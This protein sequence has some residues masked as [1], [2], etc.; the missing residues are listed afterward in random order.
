MIPS[1]INL[2]YLKDK[3]SVCVFFCGIGG[4]SMLSLAV[5]TKLNGYSVMGSDTSPTEETVSVCRQHRIPLFFSHDGDN[6]DGCNFFVYTAA[7]ASDNPELLRAKQENNIR[8]FTRSEYLGMITDSIPLSIGISGTHGKS[9]VTHLTSAVFTACGCDPIMLAGAGCTNNGEENSL[10][11]GALRIGNESTVIYEACE[12]SRS[13][14]DTHPS[15]AVILNVEREHTDIYPTLEIARNAFFEFAYRSHICVITRDCPTC[16]EI[17]K[18]LLDKGKR[19][20]TFSI[21]DKSADVFAH[22]LKNEH[23]R[24]AF[25]VAIGHTGELINNIKLNVPG[26][27]NVKNAL[28]SIAVAVACEK[29]SKNGIK[30]AL[31]GFRGI[32]RR[33]EYIGSINGADVYDD[34]AHHP[35]EIKAILTAAKALGYDRIV[36]AFQPH[37]Y[38]R[39]YEFFDDFV[40][41]LSLCDEVIVSDIF[42]AREKNVYGITS[43]KLADRIPNGIYIK[44]FDD[45]CRYLQALSHPK[46]LILTLGAGKMNTVAKRLVYGEE[47]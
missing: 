30:T 42:P 19:V 46:T 3:K 24:F 11:R 41:S 34:Y 8:I 13:F 2:P 33:F 40:D 39:T 17:E 20:L 1:L 35:T 10:C 9:T 21:S 45:I 22:S 47:N 26:I 44:S 15:V 43:K 37:T 38:S 7:I 31:E 27:H 29:F 32:A 4:V 6:I 16:N 28:A 36:C 23:G 25:D 12:Y 5:L 14:L 18:Q